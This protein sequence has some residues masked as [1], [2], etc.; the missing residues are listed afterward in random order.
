MSI[1]TECMLVSL[2]RGAWEARKL[3]KEEGKKVAND[4]GAAVD[5]VSVN[6]LIIPKEAL[7][8]VQA[9]SNAIYSHYM[10]HTLPWKDNGDRLLSRKIYM[11]FIEEHEEL[12]SA[13]KTEAYNFAHNVYPQYRAQAQFRMAGLF[14]ASDYPDPHTVASKFYARLEIDAVTEASDFRVKMDSEQ[15]ERIQERIEENMNARVG[16][17]MEKVWT[18]LSDA[19]EHYAERMK[20]D[21]RLYDSVKENLIGLC[22]ILPGLNILNDPKLAAMGKTIKERLEGFEIKPMRDPKLGKMLKAQAAAEA[23]EIVE[24]MRGF[25]AAFGAT[26]DEE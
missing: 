10:H 26:Q 9:A 16:A 7:A 23:D 12:V 19:L 3:D 22:D 18:Q 5:A 24:Q 2:H 1:T 13:L 17:V 14:K 6:K 25:M 4:S 11:K 21:G 8:K 15:A 20:T